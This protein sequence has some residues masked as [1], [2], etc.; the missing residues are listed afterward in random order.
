MKQQQ[1]ID[2]G[3]SRRRILDACAE[4]GGGKFVVKHVMPIQAERMRIT[5][6]VAGNRITHNAQFKNDL[7]AAKKSDFQRHARGNSLFRNNGD[8]TFTDTSVAS[9][10]TL[11]RWAWGSVFADFNN[12]GWQDLYVANGFITAD[13]PDRDL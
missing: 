11:G 2:A 10:V 7:D 13:D 12:D 9:G 6:A 1:L 4:T 3:M 5:E 8:G